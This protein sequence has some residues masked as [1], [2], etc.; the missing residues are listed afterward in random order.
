MIGLQFSFAAGGPSPVVL[1]AEDNRDDAELVREALIEAGVGAVLHRATDGQQALDM[2]RGG[3]RPDLVLLDLNMPRMGG[4]ET[5][6]AIKAD[7][8][9][10]TIPVVILTT[11]DADHDIRTSFQGHC[12]GYFVKPSTIDELIVVMRDVAAFWFNPHARRLTAN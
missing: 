10:R 12:S 2:L 1:L 11:S 5:L 7:P 3:L 4:R 8:D 9:L 6:Q